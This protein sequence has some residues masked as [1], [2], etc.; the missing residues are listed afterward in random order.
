MPYAIPPPGYRAVFLGSATSIDALSIFTPLEERQVEGAL[1]LMRLDFAGYPSPEVLS[2]LN[3]TCVE[4]GV[5]PWT[6]YGYIIFADTTQPTI[7]IAWQKGIA[8]MPIIIGLLLT[9]VL[10][11]L[12][13]AGIWLILPEAVRSMIEAMF[14]LGMMVL[15]M[16]V[17]VKMMGVLMPKE[18]PKE[19]EEKAK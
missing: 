4:K 8:W 1:M 11:P 5:P 19:I 18:K 3:A 15:G 12:L 9:L 6:G 13:M 14:M 16:F 17:M 2:E 10:P 7:Y